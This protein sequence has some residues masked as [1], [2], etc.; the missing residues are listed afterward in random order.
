MHFRIHS[1]LVLT[2]KRYIGKVSKF[3][4][5]T[6][7]QYG[8]IEHNNNGLFF[9]RKNILNVSKYKID[10]FFKSPTVTYKIRES[11]KNP[12]K[13]EAYDVALLEDESDTEFL[14]D[15]FFWYI[16]TKNTGSIIFSELISIF[17]EFKKEDIL[18]NKALFKHQLLNSLYTK[19][20]GLM[21]KQDIVRITQLYSSLFDSNEP[22]IFE[23]LIRLNLFGYIDELEKLDLEETFNQFIEYFRSDV[24]AA[25]KAASYLVKNKPQSKIHY[26]LWL[27]GF[28]KEVPIDY[29]INNFVELNEDYTEGF[30]H[31]LKPNQ[32]D[33]AFNKLLCVII[34]LPEN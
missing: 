25:N 17:Y 16:N 22:E 11:E 21:S 24:Q 13:F 8:F 20:T 31:N 7:D 34:I 1:M 29:A 23:P 27:N 30:L 33:K 15:Q 28:T 32:F 5:K 14:L 12:G 18:E 4:T 2:D 9:H 19:D 26:V 3:G 6:S 10:A